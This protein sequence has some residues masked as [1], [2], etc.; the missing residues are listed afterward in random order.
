LSYN[1][2]KYGTNDSSDG[3]RDS[4]D[5]KCGS[6]SVGGDVCRQARLALSII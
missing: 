2:W 4:I 3:R 1:Y 6:V 5:G